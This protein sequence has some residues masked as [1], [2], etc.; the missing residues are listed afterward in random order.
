VENN[1]NQPS[2]GEF[3]FKQFSI[4]QRVNTHKV[5][6]DSVILACF[7][8]SILK[9]KGNKIKTILDI[10]TGT[11][12]LALFF[13]K[14]YPNA[15]VDAIEI[16][17]INAQEAKENVLKNSLSDRIN[18]YACALQ[19]YKTTYP[20]DLIITNPP[21]FEND[22]LNNNTDKA[23]ARHA[24]ELTIIDILDFAFQHL[25]SAGFISFIIPQKVWLK[26]KILALEKFWLKAELTIINKN[27]NL[28]VVVLSKQKTNLFV[29]KKLTVRDKQGEFTKEFINLTKS[30]YLP[31]A[32]RGK[33]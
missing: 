3:K 7:T 29:V 24:T 12:L 20:Y 32:Y 13:A 5:G 8:Q 23:R 18:I 2:A 16:N 33:S 25:S 1:N 19:N 28:S 11:G 6:T 17:E 15:K 10:G 14:F 26:Y 21:Y 30:V 4:K 22:K 31:D 27:T 9:L